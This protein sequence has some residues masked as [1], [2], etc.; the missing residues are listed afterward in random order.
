MGKNLSFNRQESLGSRLLAACACGNERLARSLV[1]QGADAQ[2]YDPATDSDPLSAS[3]RCGSLPLSRWLLELT[4]VEP[5]SSSLNNALTASVAAGQSAC[6]ELLIN[7]GA[8]LQAEAL[9]QA[10][11]KGTTET[12][13][14]LIQTGR[15][16]SESCSSENAS[17]DFWELGAPLLDRALSYSAL[18]CQKEVFHACLLAGADMGSRGAQEAGIWVAQAQWRDMAALMLDL[19]FRP[20][21]ALEIS[22]RERLAAPWLAFEQ[23]KALDQNLIPDSPRSAKTRSL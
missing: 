20:G 11:S 3:A 7:A 1:D 5:G 12:V 8:E 2:H 17:S 9:D 16:R 13:L 15:L 19:G 14:F 21:P 22:W 6:A 23:R 18:Q 10:V 4:G